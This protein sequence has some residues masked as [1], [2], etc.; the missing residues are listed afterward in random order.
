MIPA[1]MAHLT[2]TS[3]LARH[4]Q[5]PDAELPARDVAELFSKYFSQWPE[6]RGYVLDD[7]GA[8]RKHVMVLVAGMNLRDRAGLG[9]ALGPASQVFVFQA[10]SGG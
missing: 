3:N 5:C 9:D 6:V 7:Q 4:T 1:A 2:F 8:V 10:L